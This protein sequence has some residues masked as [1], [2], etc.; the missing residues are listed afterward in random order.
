MASL[1]VSLHAQEI[2]GAPADNYDFLANINPDDLEAPDINEPDAP[3]NA[4]LQIFWEYIKLQ[5]QLTKMH[6]LEHKKA[7]SAATILVI[8]SI[9]TCKAL[10]K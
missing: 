6:V 9:I 10:K 4:K 7:Y 5:A 8:S 1:G 3:K 2:P